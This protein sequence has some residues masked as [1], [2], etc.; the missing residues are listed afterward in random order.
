M[1]SLMHP[2]VIQISFLSYFFHRL[3][4]IVYDAVLYCEEKKMKKNEVTY[5]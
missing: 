2:N 1:H 5:M 3:L 4:F